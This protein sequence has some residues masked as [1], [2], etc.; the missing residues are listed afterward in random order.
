MRPLRSQIAAAIAQGRNFS[1]TAKEYCCT[2]S[3]VTEIYT[4]AEFGR[5]NNE[6][7]NLKDQ[8]ANLQA[9]LRAR[10]AA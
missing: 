6:V 5:L 3:V 10:K 1:Q 9:E 7:S 2:T 4:R 8:V